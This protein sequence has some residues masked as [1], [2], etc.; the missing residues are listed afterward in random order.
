MIDI[1]GLICSSS[2]AVLFAYF[3][4]KCECDFVRNDDIGTFHAVM[5]VIGF[6]LF[7]S[8]IIIGLSI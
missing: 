1:I 7:V 2:G 3:L 5:C 4:D 8:G 6:L